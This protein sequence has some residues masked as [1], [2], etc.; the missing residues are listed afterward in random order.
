MTW[1]LYE[2]AANYIRN[3]IGT[4]GYKETQR[5]F[6][7]A[8]SVSDYKPSST[9]RMYV[10]ST[11]PPLTL[12]ID[13]FHNESRISLYKAFE[14]SRYTIVSSFARP[15]PNTVPIFILTELLVMD[16]L[17]NTFF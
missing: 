12:C 7:R 4:T 11:Y 17:A 5:P 14:N 16:L 2:I 6:Y 10:V 8:S 1:Q 3:G 15:F 9:T 13:R